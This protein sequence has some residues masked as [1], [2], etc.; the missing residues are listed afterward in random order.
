MQLRRVSHYSMDIR[1]ILV[2]DDDGGGGNVHVRC[3]ATSSIQQNI[4][5][6]SHLVCEDSQSR[7][8]QHDVRDM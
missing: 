3:H 7:S 5:L 2:F 6:N 1:R 8:S 4:F